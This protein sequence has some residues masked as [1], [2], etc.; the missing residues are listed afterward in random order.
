[1]IVGVNVIVGVEVIVG[2]G[3]SVEVAALV[4]VGTGVG[5][6]EGEGDLVI[7]AVLVVVGVELGEVNKS[8]S[9]LQPT[10]INSKGIITLVEDIL[11]LPAT[12]CI[13]LSKFHFKAFVSVE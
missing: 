12:I 13:F 11:M 2:V 1:M 5:E 3:V 7:V 4:A 9:L 8:I 6:G 10:I